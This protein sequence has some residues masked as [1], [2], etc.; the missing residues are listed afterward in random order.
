MDLTESPIVCALVG[1]FLIGVVCSVNYFFFGNITGFSGILG[2][3]FNL[4]LKNIAHYNWS[5]SVSFVLGVVLTYNYCQSDSN[6]VITAGG[7]TFKAF[8]SETDSTKLSTIGLSL[9]GFLVG[10]GTFVGQGCTSGHGMCGL[11]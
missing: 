10:V 4:D 7:F 5:K 6:G 11:P 9:A 8:D 1:G 2:N 3:F